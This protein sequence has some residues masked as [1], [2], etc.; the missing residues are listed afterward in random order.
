MTQNCDVIFVNNANANTYTQSNEPK[1]PFERQILQC[2]QE[3]NAVIAEL[4]KKLAHYGFYDGQVNGLIDEATRSAILQFRIQNDLNPRS[5]ST[6]E[7]LQKIGI[8]YKVSRATLSISP[9]NYAENSAIPPRMTPNACYVR[10]T[11]PPSRRVK[12]TVTSKDGSTTT[13]FLGSKL[14]E[15]NW[16][17]TICAKHF[18]S[19]DIVEIKEALKQKG[20]FDGE[21]DDRFDAHLTAGI[22]RF[23]RSEGRESAITYDTLHSLGISRPGFVLTYASLQKN[24]PSM[25]VRESDQHIARLSNDEG[26]LIFRLAH[27]RVNADRVLIAST[28]LKRDEKLL[29]QISMQNSEQTLNVCNKED[30]DFVNNITEK[31]GWGGYIDEDGREVIRIFFHT[32]ST[33]NDNRDFLRQHT[34]DAN[35]KP[36]SEL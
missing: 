35:L 6:V 12:S 22:A 2:L 36:D 11:T 7:L 23:N 21:M 18:N 4:Q 24:A 26:N 28:V 17:R 14:P 25:W 30:Y 13:V 1:T 3:P 8:S 34:P 15:I 16:H 20:Y 27:C 19:D 5:G 29:F 31:A 33:E 32:G 9:P 10:K